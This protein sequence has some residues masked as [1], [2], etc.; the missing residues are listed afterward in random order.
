MALDAAA[1]GM[2]ELG[3][4]APPTADEFREFLQ[5]IKEDVQVTDFRQ[6][7]SSRRHLSERVAGHTR[8]SLWRSSW[9]GVSS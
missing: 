7:A 5:K 2:A 6:N 1:A 8:R 4:V 9:T 3:G